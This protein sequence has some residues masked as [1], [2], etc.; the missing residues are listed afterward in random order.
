[1]SGNEPFENAKCTQGKIYC[2]NFGDDR[3]RQLAS[4][5]LRKVEQP[6]E[7]LNLPRNCKC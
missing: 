1:M 5:I 6:C 4:L 2:V 3:P 7:L